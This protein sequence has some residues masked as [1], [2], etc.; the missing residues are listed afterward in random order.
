M[1]LTAALALL[2]SPLAASRLSSPLA[3]ES[4]VKCKDADTGW[5]S[6]YEC[7]PEADYIGL[8]FDAI[9]WS[10]NG[11][12]RIVKM[13]YPEDDQNTYTNKYSGITYALPS[14]VAVSP[15]SGTEVSLEHSVI[16]NMQQ[17]VDEQI[18]EAGVHAGVPGVFSAS[19]ATKKANKT[20]L[21]GQQIYVHSKSHCPRTHHYASL[22]SLPTLLLQTHST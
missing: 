15:D 21:Q 11:K 8:G 20:V 16:R 18:S 12:S 2:T 1:K 7:L 13:I 19:V 14:H 9:S 22:S 17:I 5:E 3:D 4:L 6:Q 10:T